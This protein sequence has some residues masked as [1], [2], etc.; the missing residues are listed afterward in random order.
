M[1][2]QIAE[3]D[4]KLFR[5]LH[6]I[7]LDRFCRRILD[8]VEEITD[9]L[10]LSNH[11]RFLAPNE[12]IRGRSAEMSDSFDDMRRSMAITLLARIR[13]HDLLTDDELAQ[14]SQETQSAI[15]TLVSIWGG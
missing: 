8:E 7:M 4:W 10:A 1:R 5:K 13:F 3:P 9:N 15:E 11:Q 6:P 14:F 12:L 2:E